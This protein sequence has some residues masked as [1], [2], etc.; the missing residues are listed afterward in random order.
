[1]NVLGSVSAG[2]PYD[3]PVAVRFPLQDG[4]RADTKDSTHVRRDRNLPLGG[5]PRLSERHEGILP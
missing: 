1:M 2:S 4:A 3:D 5:Q